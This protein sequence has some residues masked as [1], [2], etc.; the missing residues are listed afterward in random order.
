MLI[1]FA[2]SVWIAVAGFVL[3]VASALLLS[4]YLGQLGRD[5]IRTMQQ[6]GGFSITGIIGRIAGRIESPP[7]PPDEP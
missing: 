5:Q 4:R 3:M 1:F 2:V 7:P 6:A